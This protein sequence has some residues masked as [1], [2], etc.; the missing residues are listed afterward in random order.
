VGAH[1]GQLRADEVDSRKVRL[2]PD[3][4]QPPAEAVADLLVATAERSLLA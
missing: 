1:P 4:R 2:Q 3:M